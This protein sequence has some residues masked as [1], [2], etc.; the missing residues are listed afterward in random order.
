M[1]TDKWLSEVEMFAARA[2]HFRVQEL[3]EIMRNSGLMVSRATIYRAINKL[4][5][6][7]KIIQI[8][9]EKERIF[10]FVREQVH[11]HFRCKKCGKIFEFF[12]NDIDNSIRESA[13]KLKIVLSEQKLILE[14]FCVYCCG[15]KN[16]KKRSHSK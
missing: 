9:N 11:Y 16:G 7:G 13:R 12:F 1:R 10:E 4:L 6:A 15:R 3:L 14:G 5:S 8:S 2:G